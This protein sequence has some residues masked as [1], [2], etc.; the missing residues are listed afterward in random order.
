MRTSAS[1]S[2]SR[3][4]VAPCRGGHSTAPCAW[5]SPTVPPSCRSSLPAYRCACH[6]IPRYTANAPGHVAARDDRAAR[7]RARRTRRLAHRARANHRHALREAIAHERYD[8]LVVAAASLRSEGFHGDEIAWLLDNAPG[9]LVII[10]PDPTTGSTVPAALASSAG[11]VR[12]RWRRRS[13]SSGQERTRSASARAMPRA[14]GPDEIGLC[15]ELKLRNR[16]APA[17]PALETTRL[18][19]PSP[20]SDGDRRSDPTARRRAGARR[21]RSP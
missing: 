9:E 6:S 7:D 18:V 16:S 3:S 11:V 1:G 19:V 4:S 2:S 15:G 21:R 20:S 5:R 17:T 10:R 12:R 14:A 13:S 8:R